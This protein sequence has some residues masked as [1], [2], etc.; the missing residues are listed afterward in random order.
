LRCQSFFVTAKSLTDCSTLNNEYLKKSDADW[1]FGIKAIR[2]FFA[3]EIDTINSLHRAVTFIAE[4]KI[5]ISLTGFVV[6]SEDMFKI[7]QKC[8]KNILISDFKKLKNEGKLSFKI[9]RDKLKKEK[10]KNLSIIDKIV[11]RPNPKVISIN[12]I[13]TKHYLLIKDI[14]DNTRNTLTN[15]AN[16]ETTN[17]SDKNKNQEIN[18]IERIEKIVVQVVNYRNKNFNWTGTT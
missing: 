18:Y 12:D 4:E 9:M 16:P 6:S 1:R 15:N 8:S 17:Q 2:H 14:I 11:S 10:Y 7:L 3:H 5:S 13:I